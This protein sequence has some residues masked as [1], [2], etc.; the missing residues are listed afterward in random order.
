LIPFVQKFTPVVA[1]A[2]AAAAAA[3]TAVQLIA[4]KHQAFEVVVCI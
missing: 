2:R 1:E 4:V 3:H